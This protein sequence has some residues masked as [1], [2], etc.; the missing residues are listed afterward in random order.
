MIGWFRK[1]F[2]ELDCLAMGEDVEKVQDLP[3]MRPDVGKIAGMTTL[4]T[5]E[6]E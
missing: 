4:L 5:S 3:W 1:G 2:E 6:A